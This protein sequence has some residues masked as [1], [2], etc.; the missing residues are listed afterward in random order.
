M[1]FTA[2]LVVGAW[3]QSANPQPECAGVSAS[4]SVGDVHPAGSAAHD[5]TGLFFTH[6]GTTK[7][8]IRI[9]DFHPTVPAGYDL[10]TWEAQWQVGDR[11]FFVQF[12]QSERGSQ[13]NWGDYDN[14]EH[15]GKGLTTG[16]LFQG[17][18]G[19]IQIVVPRELAPAGGTLEGPF[20]RT[21]GLQGNG[22][23]AVPTT[24]DE[25]ANGAPFVVNPCPGAAPAGETGAPAPLPAP[26]APTLTVATKRLKPGLRRP[27]I[28]LRSSG[29]L[30][31]VLV[32]LY[33]G[34]RVVGN[35]RLASLDGSASL[36]LRLQ[37]RLRRG[38]YQVRL[39]AVDA[40]SGAPVVAKS[41]L[42]V[43]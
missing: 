30:R 14:G 3:A 21:T 31:D 6:S 2:L 40:A 32:K 16:K 43:R 22:D 37:K 4:D 28:A 23:T 13:F 9:A 19:V 15:T 1:A 29:A 10:V 34:S 11:R 25:S 41:S 33:S 35:G 20:V 18:E 38:S 17:P 26:A 7:A 42:R 36:R 39:L 8:H 12:V 27:A 24:L 5:L